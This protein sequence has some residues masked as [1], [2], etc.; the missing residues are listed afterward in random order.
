MES[1]A[2]LA[3]VGV[4]ASLGLSC[5]DDNDRTGDQTTCIGPNELVGQPAC[6]AA[7]YQEDVSACLHAAT[8][9]EPRQLTADHNGWPACIADDDAWHLIGAGPPAAVS[10]SLAFEAM[11]TKLWLNPCR[12]SPA[13]F[14]SARD[15]YSTPEGLASRVARRQDISYPEVPG[16]DKFACGNQGIP[17]A[18]PDRCAGPAKLK[19]LIDAAF[20][21]GSEAVEPLSQA[22]RIEAALLWFFY[23]SMSSEIWTCGFNNINDCDSAA[24]YYTQIT[25]RDAP[26][27]LAVYVAAVGPE[28]HQ[29]IYDALLAARCWRDID[30]AMPATPAFVGYYDRAQAQ[31]AKAALRGVALI[32]RQRVGEILCAGGEARAAHVAF[33]EVLGGL[34]DHAASGI[35]GGAAASL[36][37]FTASPTADPSAV[38]AAQAAIDTIF[39]CP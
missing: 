34:L 27:G 5:T 35:A 12:P 18:Y 36:R 38:A 2:S 21:R 26:A 31:L 9:Y 11:A 24:G 10:R 14:L 20:Q 15:D 28:T 22:A 16:D 32:L 33:V 39:T 8:D 37:V 7:A 29:R 6:G 30:Q 4:I 13:D 23:L 3:L 25:P 19:P 1:R 17:E